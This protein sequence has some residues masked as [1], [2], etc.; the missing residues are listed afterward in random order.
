MIDLFSGVSFLF[1]G[2]S[3]A[4]GFAAPPDGLF[5]PVN[6]GDV[7]PNLVSGVN[8]AFGLSFGNS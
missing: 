1:S 3:F 7:V 4:F 5:G 2:V 6:A 8:F